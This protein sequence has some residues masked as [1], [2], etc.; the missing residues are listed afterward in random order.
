M[1]LEQ[2]IDFDGRLSNAGKCALST[3]TSTPQSPESTR[4]IRDVKLR[5]P[6]KLVFE[7]L[8]KSV[9]EILTT[10]MSVTSSSPDCEDTTSD[11]QERD[12][13]STS[14]KI[15]DENIAFSF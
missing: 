6:L 4:V 8:Q 10:Q 2:R 14:T 13:E 12:I 7:V 5:L 1:Y 11:I 15:E 9:V 3:L